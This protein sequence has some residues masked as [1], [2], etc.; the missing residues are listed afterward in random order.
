MLS[1]RGKS[2]AATTPLADRPWRYSLLT[3]HGTAY[4]Y[5]IYITYGVSLSTEKNQITPS[6]SPC[7]S[8][9]VAEPHVLKHLSSARLLSRPR[10]SWTDFSPRLITRILVAITIT[11]P[12]A[13]HPVEHPY[14]TS[15][16]KRRARELSLQL[17]IREGRLIYSIDPGIQESA[18]PAHMA[19]AA[20]KITRL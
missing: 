15:I 18:R 16:I 14:K 11:A 2:E 4:T 1:D 20:T 12:T 7:R 5:Y 9:H 8:R 3:L 17:S 19:T 10:P 6:Q 13:V